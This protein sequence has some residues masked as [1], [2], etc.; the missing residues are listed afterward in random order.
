[1][2]TGH[3]VQQ[4]GFITREDW[5]GCSPDGLI[6]ET[7]G[8]E[9]KCP[10]GLRKADD[11]SFKTLSDQPHYY[12][13]VQFSLWVTGRD[14]WHFYQ[15]TPAA[16]RLETVLQDA[17][18]QAVNL[19]LLRQF[20]AEYLHEVAN[21]AAEH[22]APKRGEVDTP[23][24][25]RMMAEY[26]QMQEAIDRATE[27]KAELLADMVRISGD[28]NA[29]FAGRNLTRVDRKGSVSYAKAIA[30]LLQHLDG[31]TGREGVVVIAACNHPEQLDPAIR[32]AGPDGAPA[33][34][35]LGAASASHATAA[36]HASHA[37]V[38]DARPRSN[39]VA[40]NS[41]TS[42]YRRSST[43]S[44]HSDPLAPGNGLCANAS[45]SG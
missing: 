38:A 27:R 45:G 25:Y 1:M 12:A 42:A 8:L 10:F 44:V 26:E 11:P 24:A 21:N 23:E 39:A 36:T 40:P 17:E 2:E 7:D 29:V 28:K 35:A 41:A 14:C 33:L 37:A 43:G 30:G 19:P 15:W 5:A 32:R 13:Q 3:T 4:V 34:I 9:I 6:G 22:L 16:T 20:H 18:W 31:M